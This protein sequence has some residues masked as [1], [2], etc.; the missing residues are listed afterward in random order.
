M[1]PR[2]GFTLIEL[3]VVIAII[4]VLIALLLPAVQMAREAARRTQCR[5]N[6]KQIGVALHN[7]H[8]VYGVFPPIQTDNQ[9]NTNNTRDTAY[10]SMNAFLLPDLEQSATFN[11]INFKISMGQITGT[12]G[13]PI[14]LT[15]P[16]LTAANNIVEGFLCP[17][18]NYASQN[19]SMNAANNNYVANYGWPRNS[20]GIDGRRPV[21][22]TS[23]QGPNGFISVSTLRVNSLDDGPVDTNVGA[24]DIVDG[25]A[26]TAAYS[27]RLINTLDNAD[28]DERRMWYTDLVRTPKTQ[29][30][31]MDFCKSATVPQTPWSRYIG[32]AW[33]SGWPNVG[34]TYMHLMM[35]NTRNCYTNRS[36]FD[37]SMFTGASSNHPG[38]VNVLMADGAVRSVSNS[39]DAV[40]WWSIGSRNGQETIS[41]TEF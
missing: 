13:G 32:G 38:G 1:K 23:L 24:R 7:Y 11:A 9:F 10:F 8:D 18:D 28:T 2:R 37:G 25:L 31:I 5:N 19:K 20:T 35:P 4:A 26:F 34:N 39:V 21:T 16:N 3:L 40:V 27:E 6:L 29:Q 41:N 14:P 17:S 36:F 30:R 33:I 15:S 12:S 22:A